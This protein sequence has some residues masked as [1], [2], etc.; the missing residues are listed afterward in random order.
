MRR[1][2]GLFLLMFSLIY[3]GGSLKPFLCSSSSYIIAEDDS[4]AGL[5]ALKDGF[6][7]EAL[8][9]FAQG[10]GLTGISY[11]IL[12]GYIYAMVS[13]PNGIKG[14]SRYDI[15]KIGR[16]GKIS[17]LGSPKFKDGES[18]YDAF[19]LK[20]GTMDSHG[21]YY[22][23]GDPVSRDAQHS[24]KGFL[25]AVAIGKNPLSGS[26]KF[27]KKE[28]KFIDIDEWEA[29]KNSIYLNGVGKIYSLS[30]DNLYVIDPKKLTVSKAEFDL[31]G[32]RLSDFDV[33]DSWAEDGSSFYF[34]A[35]KRDKPDSGEVFL[36]SVDK[37]EP[38]K[39][40]LESIGDIDFGSTASA[41]GCIAPKLKES[42][43]ASEVKVGDSYSYIFKISNPLPYPIKV[44][45]EDKLPQGI[46]FD[47]DV[48]QSIAK[49]STFI[50]SS[51]LRV[52]DLVID[53]FKSL[54][55]KLK[56][57][58]DS[59]MD[60]SINNR[61]YLYFR[62][63]RYG[64]I[65]DYK[66]V[67]VTSPQIDIQERFISN[68]DEDGSGSITVGDTLTFEVEAINV[69][70]VPLVDVE[71]GEP[72]LTPDSK[73][74]T[75]LKPN[76]SCILRG[77]YKVRAEDEKQGKII[78]TAN[79]STRDGI[80]K[81]S[82]L[83]IKVSA[84]SV[85][86]DLVARLQNSKIE[87]DDEVQL[88]VDVKNRGLS[89]ATDLTLNLDTPPE[90]S[91]NKKSI[92]I[93]YID[94]DSSKRFIF[95]LEGKRIGNHLFKVVLNSQEKGVKGAFAI[96]RLEV[97]AP[98]LSRISEK[99]TGM[100]K[101]FKAIDVDDNETNIS[102]TYSKTSVDSVYRNAAPIARNDEITVS[103]N[104]NN[105]IDISKGLL[106]NDRDI[107]GDS[108]EIVKFEID[109]NGDG[110][111]EEY[112]PKDLVEIDGVGSLLI[113]KDGSFEFTPMPNYNGYV[114]TITYTVGDGRGGLSTA[115]ADI[116]IGEEIK[117]KTPQPSSSLKD[118]YEY[119]PETQTAD[120]SISLILL[121]ILNISVFLLFRREIARAR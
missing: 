119:Q 52:D 87:V 21:N 7:K 81:N 40:T 2:L 91:S 58:V 118:D 4:E 31:R 22:S 101:S 37:K 57:L 42:V 78:S 115:K 1:I 67:T 86:L 38:L 6:E 29:P 15:V 102:K 105:L 108:L 11:N 26:L 47:E 69:G 63:F 79:V 9:K 51:E 13:E 66:D 93:P 75:T 20:N 5:F 103:L 62:D 39:A 99:I 30:G 106:V 14:W 89:M 73:S 114:P 116:T 107:D 33:I 72:Q 90:I 8:F 82:S 60:K 121:F 45:F 16:Y 68:R 55:F 98:K 10:F 97:V 28:L 61:A 41:T 24:Q 94:S 43:S 59:A 27:T 36:I 44:S 85:K 100:T 50:N 104:Q 3:A 12:D 110:V 17:N 25:Y 18:I 120:G 54:Q 83:E 84:S 113:Q 71:I 77:T 109:T 23:V 19:R 95:K 80:S 46:S 49:N 56:V 112:K 65:K 74:C 48:E 70:R 64:S 34:Y 117:I 76:E 96:L 53:K 32:K 92:K 111:D 35:K 88:I